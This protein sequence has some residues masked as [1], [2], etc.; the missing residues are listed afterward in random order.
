[1]LKEDSYLKYPEIIVRIPLC[2]LR[3]IGFGVS[4]CWL[5]VLLLVVA[6]SSWLGFCYVSPERDLQSEQLFL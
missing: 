6:G 3:Y 4:G 2:K 5:A 1:M